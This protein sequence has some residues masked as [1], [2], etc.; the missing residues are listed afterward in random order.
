LTDHERSTV[1]RLLNDLLLWA[2]EL[3]TDKELSDERLQDL[4]GECERKVGQLR[5]MMG[6]GQDRDA[7]DGAGNEGGWA[8]L[9]SDESLAGLIRRVDDRFRCCVEE[10]SARRQRV[11]SELNS[12]RRTQR[13]TKA[14]QGIESA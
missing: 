14:Y 11:A 13:A 12:L 1:L 7:R 4:V 2:E 8:A 9:R 5:T 6:S 3:A 10:L